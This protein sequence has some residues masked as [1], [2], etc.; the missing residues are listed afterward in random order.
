M[1]KPTNP[2][3]LTTFPR[4]ASTA[5]VTPDSGFV[6]R[7]R[8]GDAGLAATELD[9]DEGGPSGGSAVDEAVRPELERDHQPEQLAEIG[10]AADVPLEIVLRRLRLQETALPEGLARE[11]V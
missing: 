7:A 1:F 11:D 8:V 2:P 4:R 10:L 9:I 5:M 3:V 6:R